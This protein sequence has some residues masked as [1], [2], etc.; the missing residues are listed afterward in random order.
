M[1]REKLSLNSWIEEAEE[2]QQPLADFLIEFNMRELN[3]CQEELMERMQSLLEVME[4]SVETG[5]RG[6]RSRSGLTGG[7]AKRLK[8]ACDSGRYAGLLGPLGLDAV[9]YATAV[10]ECNAGMG[11]IVA[12]PTAGAAGVLPGVFFALKKHRSL[13]RDTLAKGMVVAG[14]IGMV[15]AERASL[16]GATGGCQAECGSAGAMAAG[17]AVSMLGGTPRQAGDAV[18]M[19]FKNI[20]GLVCDPVAGLVEIPCIKRNGSCA[21]QALLAAELALSGV[22]SFISPDEAIDAMKQVG[23][24]LPCA[25]R[26]TGQGG[27][28]AAP[29]A[30]A[31]TREYFSRRD[32]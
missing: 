4:K 20:L 28:A 18:A 12:A 9:I 25:L 13:D 17:A 24:A 32:K 3:C 14:S 6:G 29:R 2:W 23:D 22:A 16:A 30:V 11:R 31:W 27:M 1:K 5:L 8:E 10:S 7:D 26:E 21:L 19:V 15:I